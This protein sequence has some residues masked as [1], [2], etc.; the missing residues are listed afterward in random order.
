MKS[1]Y[2]ALARFNTAYFAEAWSLILGTI[3][4]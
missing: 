1:A 3:R 2:D 4:S